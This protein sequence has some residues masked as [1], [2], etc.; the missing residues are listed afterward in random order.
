MRYLFG[1]LCICTV[2]LVL[3]SAS[4]QAGQEG[5][6]SEPNLQEPVLSSEP[7]PEE[8]ALQLQ[9]DSA[10]VDVVPSPLRTAD[11]YT[12][13]EMEVR[14]RRARIGLLS[15]TCVAV[16]GAVLFGAGAA[17]AGSSQDWDVFSRANGA[18]LISGMSLMIGGAVGM[19]ATGT[20]LGS[21]KG[22][23]RGLREARYEG[24][25]RAQWDLAQS[26]LVF[27]DVRRRAA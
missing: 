2:S 15:T 16:G 21:R 19:I 20:M 18:L 22:E 1:F 6:T 27:S 5:T 10:G 14:V 17:R 11:G 25:R 12:V 8:P 26:R 9:L 4:A 3:Q 23:L 7:A 13:E 24:P